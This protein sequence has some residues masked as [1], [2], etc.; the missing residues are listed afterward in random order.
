[1]TYFEAIII[2]TVEGITEFL[3]ISST[4]HMILTSALLG[5]KTSPFL[6]LFIISIQ[7]GSILSVV[8]LY[9]ERFFQSLKFYYLI[10]TAVIPTVIIAFI[11][12]KY[13]DQALGSVL[14]VAINLLI[15]G[16][17]MIFLENYFSKKNIAD[18]ALTYPKAIRIGILQA[19]SIFPGVSRSAATIYG[20]M[21]Q[22]LNRKDAAE[23]SF[24]LAVPVMFLATVKDAYDFFKESHL[25]LTAHDYQ[26]L[27]LGN[28]IA[29]I[30]AGAT[31][32]FLISFIVQNGFKIFAYYRILIGI[33][34]LILYKFFNFSLEM[35]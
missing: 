20:G 32:K 4:G 13:V 34:V 3:P 33:V 14:V 21:S 1:M 17:A 28:A 8:W 10:A 7:F 35:M 19:I 22:G 6:N 15:G 30:V 25:I 31:I 12:K 26:L 23:F 2:A 24:F 9:W 11:L 5:L 18:A 27:L 29:F 16:I